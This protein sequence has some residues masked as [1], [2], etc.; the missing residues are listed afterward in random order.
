LFDYYEALSNISEKQILFAFKYFDKN[1]DGSI[2]VVE[3][4]NVII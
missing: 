1:N 4:I 3:M 2:S